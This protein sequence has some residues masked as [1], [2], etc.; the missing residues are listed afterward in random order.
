M[1]KPGNWWLGAVLWAA[2]CGGDTT[3]TP[4]AKPSEPVRVSRPA[5]PSTKPELL[6][7]ATPVAAYVA[8]TMASAPSMKTVVY[9]GATWCEPCQRF[10][11]ALRA[12]Q[13]DSEFRGV[14]F[15]EYD[16]DRHKPELVA[17]GYHSRLIPLFVLPESDG[18]AGSRRLEGSIKGETAIQGNLV[19][20]LRDLLH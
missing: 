14:R 11:D 6:P 3:G 13:L 1:M 18:R 20:R 19:P 16:L 5:E 17:D 8:E 2:S 9:V 7:G 12:G 4:E 15:I 10:H